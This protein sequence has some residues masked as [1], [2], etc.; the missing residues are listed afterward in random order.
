MAPKRKHQDDSLLGQA[1]R[2]LQSALLSTSAASTEQSDLREHKV[3]L[4]GKTLTLDSEV[5]RSGS[6]EKGQ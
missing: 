4:V 2:S 3:L 5:W 6:D 1:L